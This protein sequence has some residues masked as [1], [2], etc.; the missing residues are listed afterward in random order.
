MRNPPVSESESSE[1][2]PKARHTVG[3]R[4]GSVWTRVGNCTLDQERSASTVPPCT[5]L[6]SIGGQAHHLVFKTWVCTLSS[7]NVEYA[8]GTHTCVHWYDVAVRDHIKL[9]RLAVSRFYG[10]RAA[11]PF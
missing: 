5:G 10:S 4:V 11:V 3:S 8:Q 6:L 7:T 9:L 1:E 2:E